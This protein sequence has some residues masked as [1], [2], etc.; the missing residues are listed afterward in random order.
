MVLKRCLIPFCLF[1]ML[2]PWA[3]AE[4]AFSFPCAQE[5][6]P[7]LAAS[8]HEISKE[9]DLAEEYRARIDNWE[10]EIPISGSLIVLDMQFMM[11]HL[12]FSKDFDY[13]AH[14]MHLPER[15]ILANHDLNVSNDTSTPDWRAVMY[16]DEDDPYSFHYAST[17]NWPMATVRFY[18]D[19]MD[20]LGEYLEAFTTCVSI[21]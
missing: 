9:I 6:S 20:S 10:C 2:S 16:P 1:V 18:G 8:E 7:F 13:E 17:W 12:Q 3:A 4:S 5:L 21:F 11:I 15:I 14:D 19:Y